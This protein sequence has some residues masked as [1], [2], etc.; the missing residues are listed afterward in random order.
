MQPKD[1]PEKT[2]ENDRRMKKKL[3]KMMK[4]LAPKQP[5]GR[6]KPLEMF[7]KTKI[8]SFCLF[9]YLFP[10]FTQ[11]LMCRPLLSMKRME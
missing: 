1:S 3:D 6:F 8:Y 5:L 4:D 7:S 2:P 10:H 11:L 9:I